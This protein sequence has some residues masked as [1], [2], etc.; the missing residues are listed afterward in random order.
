[1]P[2]NV[3]WYEIEADCELHHFPDAG[4]L[5]RAETLREPLKPICFIPRVI[6]SVFII[7][8]KIKLL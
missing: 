3:W 5:V 7:N 8:I 2:Y 4:K 6:A 1:M